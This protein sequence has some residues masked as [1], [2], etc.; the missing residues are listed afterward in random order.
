MLWYTMKLPL[1][2]LFATSIVKVTKLE[3]WL[4]ELKLLTVSLSEYFAHNKT[5]FKEWVTLAHIFKTCPYKSISYCIGV[6]WR[7]RAK[8]LSSIR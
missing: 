1:D 5:I 4:L 7:N 2:K 6:L 3:K 8:S